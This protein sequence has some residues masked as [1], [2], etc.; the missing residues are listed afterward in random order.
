MKKCYRIFEAYKG[1]MAVKTFINQDLE[2][3]IL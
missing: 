2:D 3:E 1:V